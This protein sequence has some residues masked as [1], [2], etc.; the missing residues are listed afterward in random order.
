LVIDVLEGRK[1]KN[2]SALAIGKAMNDRSYV[3]IMKLLE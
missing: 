2:T 1:G 3:I